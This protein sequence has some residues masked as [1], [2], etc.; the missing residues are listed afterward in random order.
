M[1]SQRIGHSSRANYGM[2][3]GSSWTGE[4]GLWSRIVPHKRPCDRYG[5]PWTKRPDRRRQPF[6]H[7]KIVRKIQI[8]LRGKNLGPN[9]KTALKRVRS[10]AETALLNF[11]RY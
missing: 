3:W 5:I 9:D 2:Q 4:R 1:S 10:P 11:G 7:K 8:W 6:A